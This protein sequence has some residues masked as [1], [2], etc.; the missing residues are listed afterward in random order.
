MKCYQGTHHTKLCDKQAL[1]QWTPLK[2]RS[3]NTDNITILKTYCSSLYQWWEPGMCVLQLHPWNS[4]KSNGLVLGKLV[5]FAGF[6]LPIID[7][8]GRDSNCFSIPKF[9]LS[10]YSCILWLLLV[11][12][13]DLRGLLHQV[14]DVDHVAPPGA[15]TQKLPKLDMLTLLTPTIFELFEFRC[16]EGYNLNLKR[17]LILKLYYY[18]Y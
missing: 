5:I 14:T 15:D 16:P 8:P 6:L 3:I 17:K 2:A 7:Y 10:K 4:R 1:G 13:H 11:L 18:W 12:Q 9:I